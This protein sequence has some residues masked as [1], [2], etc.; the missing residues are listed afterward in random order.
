MPRTITI[1]GLTVV[2]ETPERTAQPPWLLV[3]GMFVGAWCFDVF[4]RVLAARGIASYA[5]N[6]R[7]H[8]DSRPDVDIRGV[9]ITDFADDVREVA[10]AIGTEPPVIVGHSMGGLIAQKVAEA[11]GASAT[12]LLCSAPPAGI[13][14]AR[15]H[16]I[17]HMVRWL[18][19]MLATRPIVPVREAVYALALHRMP[20]DS[21][22]GVFARMVPESGRAA[23]E[24]SLGL[25]RI[26]AARV[27]CPVLVVSA[28]E[29]LTVA[30]GVGRRLARKYD[31]TYWNLS[32]H[33]HFLIQEPGCEQIAAQIASWVETTLAARAARAVHHSTSLLSPGGAT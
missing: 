17:P 5:I 11:D 31:A 30:P 10:R 22:A 14:V 7:G 3:P 8:Y 18:V 20:P 27:R 13:L 4:Q 16:L 33:A 28:S 6:L 25:V 1:N 32:Q 19:P 2:A 26:D 29:D 21:R 12:V 9:S 15:P 23:R 24:L